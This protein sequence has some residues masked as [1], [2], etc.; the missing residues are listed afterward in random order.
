MSQSKKTASPSTYDYT[1]KTNVGNDQ[2]KDTRP[3]RPKTAE[4][5]PRSRTGPR[6]NKQAPANPNVKTLYIGRVYYD[7]LDAD[8]KV[9]QKLNQERLK[10]LKE[11]FQRYGAVE[12]FEPNTAESFVHVTYKER[13]AA[14]DAIANLI[15][16][17]VREK[18]IEEIKEQL[19]KS[20]QPEAVCPVLWKYR[21]EWSRTAEGGQEQQQ[22]STTS[23][24]K[25]KKN[26]DKPQ[27]PATPTE[28]KK[29]PTKRA[30]KK[31]ENTDQPSAST[32]T[33]PAVVESK[34][35]KTAEPSIQSLQISAEHASLQVELNYLRKQRSIV[36]GQI[37]AEKSRSSARE[38]RIKK[39]Q[40]EHERVRKQSLNLES[41]LNSDLSWKNA[42]NERISKLQE[43]VDH[44][45]QQ[46][47]IVNSMLQSIPQL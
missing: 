5:K 29:Q 9:S 27:S 12:K 39:L 44:L 3:R 7:E 16:R 47:Q 43:E 18:L 33:A 13:S 46:Q 34:P 32:T 26:A 41:Q 21:F 38:E 15:Q 22:Q 6:P 31:T 28:T 42:A 11:V 40:E 14:E 2:E 24:S 35:V 19:R 17:P 4:G 20:N 23:T 1:K 36:Q 8:Q 37:Q 45:Q 10:L 30:T 25:P